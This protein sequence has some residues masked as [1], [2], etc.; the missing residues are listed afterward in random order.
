M[1]T[2]FLL[3]QNK[4]IYPGSAE[5]GVCA[6]AAVKCI[7]HSLTDVPITAPAAASCREM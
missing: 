4:D 5:L 7:C 1:R 3:L 2:G 6:E